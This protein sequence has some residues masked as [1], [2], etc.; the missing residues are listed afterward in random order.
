MTEINNIILGRRIRAIRNSLKLDQKQ[1][2]KKLDI[3]VSALSNWE[4]GRNKPK[5][6]FLE[7]IAA[8]GNTTVDEMMD[9]EV[10][11]YKQLYQQQKQRADEL[12]NHVKNLEMDSYLSRER[13]DIYKNKVSELEKRWSELRELVNERTEKYYEAN[14]TAYFILNAIKRRMAELQEDD[15]DR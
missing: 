14:M 7:K 8:L 10:V 6:M 15:N 5:E 13:A 2:A 11:D 4:C 12:E 3:T 9:R 1:F